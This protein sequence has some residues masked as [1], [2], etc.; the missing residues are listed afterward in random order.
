[1]LFVNLPVPSVSEDSESARRPASSPGT[2]GGGNGGDGPS[3]GAGGRPGGGGDG[4][5]GGG[6]GG[7]SGGRG[8]DGGAGGADGSGDSGGGGG[9]TGD[10]G[11]CSGEGAAVNPGGGGRSGGELGGEV[12]CTQGAVPAATVGAEVHA[13]AVASAAETQASGAATSGAATAEAA[14]VAGADRAVRAVGEARV[15]WGLEPLAARAAATATVV[16]MAALAGRHTAARLSRCTSPFAV[17]HSRTPLSVTS[18]SSATARRCAVKQSAAVA[19]SMSELANPAASAARG[20]A[21]PIGKVRRPHTARI[22]DVAR[23]G[24]VHKCP[25]R[26]HRK[27]V[28]L[29]RYIELGEEQARRRQRLHGRR[30]SASVALKSTGAVPAGGG[31]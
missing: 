21:T 25:R 20:H 11:D 26:S 14:A 22:R 12:G 16:A 27:A 24:R 18:H 6:D 28:E 29:A 31:R 7:S 30:T 8:V 23:R 13:A 15:A 19:A 1:M 3:G 4:G 10:G 2:D 9:V 5:E 17:R